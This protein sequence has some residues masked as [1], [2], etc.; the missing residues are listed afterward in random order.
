MSLFD[1]LLSV[2]VGGFSGVIGSLIERKFY[3]FYKFRKYRRFRSKPIIMDEASF[4]FGEHNAGRKAA[5]EFY[6]SRRVN[7][8]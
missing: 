6:K 4:I 1:I 8:Q 7:K 3:V 2:F 5:E